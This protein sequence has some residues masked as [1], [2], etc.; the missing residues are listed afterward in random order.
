[1]TFVSMQAGM[2]PALALSALTSSAAAACGVRGGLFTESYLCDFSVLQLPFKPRPPT[3][4]PPPGIVATQPSDKF[5]RVNLEALVCE[6]ASEETR[7]LGVFMDG[8]CVY[9]R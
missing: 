2:A 5:R 7:V 3:G 9:Q 1:M 8:K 4:Q 6:L